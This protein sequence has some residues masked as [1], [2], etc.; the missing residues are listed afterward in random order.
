MYAVIENIEKSGNRYKNFASLE[1][2]METHFSQMQS[3]VF[4]F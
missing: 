4:K 3:E 2:V 1:K